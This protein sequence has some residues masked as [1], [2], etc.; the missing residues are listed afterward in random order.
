MPIR[1]ERITPGIYCHHWEGHISTDEVV[2]SF[3]LEKKLADVDHC[4]KYIVI[5]DGSEVR[6]FPFNLMKLS[7]AF[8]GN[9]LLTLAYNAPALGHKLGEIIGAMVH[10]PFEFYDDWDATLERAHQLLDENTAIVFQSKSA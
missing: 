6:T 4:A 8:S 5:L 2:R 1:T 9:E 3:E 10:L 7:K